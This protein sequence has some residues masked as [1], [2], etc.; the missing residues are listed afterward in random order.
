MFETSEYIYIV[1]TFTS[2][3]LRQLC[4]VPLNNISP[5]FL[6]LNFGHPRLFIQLDKQLQ[7]FLHSWKVGVSTVGGYSCNLFICIYISSQGSV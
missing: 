6:M 5:V 2:D 3:I 4:V 7:T 1:S